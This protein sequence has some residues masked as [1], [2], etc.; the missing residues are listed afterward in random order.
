MRLDRI[1]E[2]L[3]GG[4][5]KHFSFKEGD[6]PLLLFLPPPPHVKADI[7]VPWPMAAAK[8]LKRAP[9]EIAE[10]AAD[11]LSKIEGVE[12]AAARPPGFINATL[13]TKALASIFNGMLSN[14]EGFAE[15][16]PV[17]SGNILLEFVSANPTGPLHMASGRGA[18]LGDSLVRIF[19]FLGYKASSEYYVNDAGRQV[20]LL[21]KSLKARYEGNEPPEDGYQG[22]YLKE[23]AAELPKGLRWKESEFA[24]FAV[25]ELLKRH[26]K[27][28]SD[29]GVNFDRWFPESEL[30]SQK[31]LDKALAE[32]KRLGKTYEKEGAVWFGSADSEVK[33]DKDRVLVKQDGK[34]TYFLPDIAYHLNKYDRGFT[35]LIDI[36]GADH[37]GYVP[38]MKAA[39]AALGK[40]ADSFSVIIHQL[41]LLNRGGQAVKMSK[42]A[43]EFVSLRELMEE[44]G[45]DACRFFFALR[46]PNSHLNFDLDL[47]KKRSSDNPVF[48]VQYVHARICSI[49]RQAKEKGITYTRPET[50]SFVP[51]RLSDEERALLVKLTWFQ[52]I[53]E[54]CVRDLSPHHLTNYLLELAGL[55]HPFYDKH[56]VLD[57]TNPGLTKFRLTLCDGIRLAISTGLGLIGVS[58][59]ESM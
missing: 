53:L 7:S 59:P 16:D 13:S 9:L 33:D 34:P 23:L 2:S 41:V 37:H 38:R 6:F 12:S 14:P 51:G 56:K 28:M 1:R 15:L 57:E 18:T 31:A 27:D 30:H 11:I 32:L 42:R 17:P 19:R 26:K 47:A 45:K 55:F 40:P 49:F 10:E 36:W 24:D 20:E 29:F 50:V 46:T 21:G 44:V 4:L 54:A 58:A 39:V 35:K 52:E 8:K 43:G 25:K 5:Q 22:D 3:K 48:Y